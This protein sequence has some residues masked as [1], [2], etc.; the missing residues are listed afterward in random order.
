MKIGC[1][2]TFEGLVQ[3]P[4][5]WGTVGL[6]PSED[7]EL[8]YRRAIAALI[9]ALSELLG[10]GVSVLGRNGSPLHHFR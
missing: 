10:R 9:P 5:G 7:S 3:N 8:E 6:A 1:C 4:P 2:T